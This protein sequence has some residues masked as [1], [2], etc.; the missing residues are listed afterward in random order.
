VCRGKGKA[1]DARC[2]ECGKNCY[3]IFPLMC[4]VRGAIRWPKYIIIPRSGVVRTQLE[5]LV[6]PENFTIHIDYVHMAANL[7]YT[8][9][10][11]TDI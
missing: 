9:D 5:E 2:M 4:E 6:S 7:D 1:I 3:K 8:A 11:C 10:P